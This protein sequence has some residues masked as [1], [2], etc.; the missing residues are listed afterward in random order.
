MY[1]VPL[2]VPRVFYVNSVLPPDA[3]ESPGGALLG[4]VRVRRTLPFG[5]EALHLYQARPQGRKVNY[6]DVTGASCLHGNMAP[7]R[8]NLA[9]A[10]EHVPGAPDLNGHVAVVRVPHC[11]PQ[12]NLYWHALYCEASAHVD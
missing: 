12:P 3:P 6:K 11:A 7:H 1:A 8:C 2:R 4:G 5:R 9:L 10:A